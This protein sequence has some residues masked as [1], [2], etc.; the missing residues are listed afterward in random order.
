MQRENGADGVA[1]PLYSEVEFPMPERVL[2]L[3]AIVQQQTAT[4]ICVYIE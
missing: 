1:A 4:D 3:A 2:D